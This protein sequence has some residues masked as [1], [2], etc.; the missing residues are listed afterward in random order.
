MEVLKELTN[1]KI[2]L[3]LRKENKL[4]NTETGYGRLQWLKYELEEHKGEFDV[5]LDDYK[6]DSNLKNMI[7]SI[8]GG[9]IEAVVIW[10]LD[11]INQKH[12]IGLSTIC[13]TK[14]I[15]LISFCESTIE[16]NKL[17][18]KCNEALNI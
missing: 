8:E 7:N 5:F 12:L 3:Y 9:E 1:K 18:V 14:G 17:I 13:L 11:D 10:A 2:G 4:E 15:P 16:L 6:E